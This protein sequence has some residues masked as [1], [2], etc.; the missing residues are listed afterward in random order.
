M[1][2]FNDEKPK[3][4]KR[5]IQP[6]GLY[7][8]LGGDDEGMSIYFSP[9]VFQPSGNVS[10]SVVPSYLSTPVLRPSGHGVLSL[11]GPG[12][13]IQFLW[14]NVLIS[15]PPRMKGKDNHY[16]TGRF[17]CIVRCVWSLVGRTALC[18]WCH[19]VCC[20]IRAK[21]SQSQG[22]GEVSIRIESRSLTSV[23]AP[24]LATEIDK[25]ATSQ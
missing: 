7:P 9:L 10:M 22:R 19:N 11:L 17:S 15:R 1:F 24:S 5:Q 23:M 20:N 2:H 25:L 13:G 14:D 3:L 4:L 18:P 8:K 12:S 6:Y 16:T 21:M